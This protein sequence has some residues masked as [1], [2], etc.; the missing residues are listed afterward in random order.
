MNQDSTPEEDDMVGVRLVVS[1]LAVTALIAVAAPLAQAGGGPGSGLPGTTTCRSVEHEGNPHQVINLTDNLSNQDV[2]VNSPALLCDLGV[3]AT[4]VTGP[5]LTTV[6]SPNVVMCY[7]VG[8]G[9]G[10]KIPATII[11]LFGTHD[12]K[13]GGFKLVCVPAQLPD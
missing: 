1:V 4:L 6:G 8:G 3:A 10:D 11:D 2:K 12:V 13:I 9:G 7:Q 5:N